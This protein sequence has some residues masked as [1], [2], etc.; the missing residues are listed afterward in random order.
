LKKV[1]A[2]ALLTVALAACGGGGGSG[3]S[4]SGGNAANGKTVFTG[5]GGCIV[6]H[7]VQGVSTGT[8]GPELTH[9][10]TVAKIRK[11]GVDDEAYI[12]ES[13]VTPSAYVVQGF[14]DGQMPAD[15]GTRLTKQQIDDLVA[16]LV[17]L[18]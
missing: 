5:T 16:Y 11:P 10:G 17:S 15:L 2:V 13:L 14:P 18:Q 1:L 4:P 3:A 8:I 9:I 7:T 6:C 12:R